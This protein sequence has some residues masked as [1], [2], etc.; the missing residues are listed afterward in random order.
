VA[1]FEHRFAGGPPPERP[2]RSGREHAA[3]EHR[4]WLRHLVAWATG[5][6]LLAFGVLVVGDLDRS[7]ALLSVVGLWTL[8]L[9]IDFLISFSHTL[10]PRDATL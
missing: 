1:R 7:S 6:A 8:V 9:A 10:W 4:E 2:P 5:T 3:R